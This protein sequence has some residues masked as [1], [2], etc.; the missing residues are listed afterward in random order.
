MEDGAGVTC[1]PGQHLSRKSGPRQGTWSGCE[2]RP[3]L[4][5][6]KK[7][8]SCAKIDTPTSTYIVLQN[9]THMILVIFH[10]IQ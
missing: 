3:S 7:R 6:G 10:K 8:V 1:V 9:V 2:L 4:E 5:R